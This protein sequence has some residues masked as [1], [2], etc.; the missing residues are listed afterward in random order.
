[1]RIP[2]RKAALA[3]AAL[4]LAACTSPGPRQDGPPPAHR[5]D[6]QVAPAIPAPEPRSRYGNPD[7]YEVFGKRY[8]VMDTAEGY[9]ERG[10]ASWYGTK[11]HGRRTSSGEPYDM[12]AFT[13]AHKTLPLPTWVEVTNLRNRRSILVR[14]NDRGPFVANRI[15]DLSYA[16]ARELDIVGDGT[17]L[18]EVRALTFGEAAGGDRM[19]AA[20]P[21]Q[22][23]AETLPPADDT[24][25]PQ[26][27]GGQT[28]DAP[29]L[30]VQVGAFSERANAERMHARLLA[31]DFSDAFIFEDVTEERRLYRVRVGPIP[32][33]EAYDATVARLG[34][35]GIDSVHMIIE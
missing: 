14:V 26:P 16:A 5:A 22:A 7:S 18:V 6:R 28:G 3:A 35:L 33:V 15:I 4:L 13:A 32:S 31:E 25:P 19:T 34:A 11:F 8:H 30:Y 29:V 17:G 10:V 21:A 12:H 23:P 1:M 9:R 2:E 20:A 27:A 24:A